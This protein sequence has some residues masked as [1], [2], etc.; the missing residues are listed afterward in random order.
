MATNRERVMAVIL[1]FD[2]KEVKRELNYYCEVD[3][4]Y[5]YDLVDA[6]DDAYTFAENNS[7]RKMLKKLRTIMVT[8]GAYVHAPVNHTHGGDFR[9]QHN[10]LKYENSPPEGS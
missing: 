8:A 2:D 6:L 3:R 4:E 9:F 10:G 7:D 5:E 1:A